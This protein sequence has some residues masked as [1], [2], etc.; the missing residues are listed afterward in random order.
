MAKKSSK[1]KSKSKS[2]S[3]AKSASQKK[4]STKSASKK[5]SKS[6]KKEVVKPKVEIKKAEMPSFH[7]SDKK[8]TLG[9]SNYPFS[10]G[11]IGGLITLLIGIWVL[12]IEITSSLGK[13]IAIAWII[14]GIGILIGAVLLK[15]EKRF[16]AGSATLTICS[17][18]ALLTLAGLIIGP[19]MALIGGLLTRSRRMIPA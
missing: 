15:S 16:K 13:G 8:V 11:L 17:L 5:S 3:K 2:K 6:S 12:L 10:L 4:K 7:K 14:L 19:L 9:H 1:K 18:L